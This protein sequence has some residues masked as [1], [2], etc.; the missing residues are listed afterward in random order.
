MNILYVS[1]SINSYEIVY[2][3]QGN[4]LLYLMGL[5]N[6]AGTDENRAVIIS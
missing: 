3:S 5:S 2:L 1:L 6:S 4:I